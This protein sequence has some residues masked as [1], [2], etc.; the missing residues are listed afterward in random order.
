VTQWKPQI[1]L[2]SFALVTLLLA[3]TAIGRVLGIGF[4]QAPYLT[5]LVLIGSAWLGSRFLLK[6]A[7]PPTDD[8]ETEG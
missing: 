6:Q 8:S 3:G 1:A 7:E 4:D 2:D 5:A